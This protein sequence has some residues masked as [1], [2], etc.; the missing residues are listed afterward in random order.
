MRSLHRRSEHDGKFSAHSFQN[1]QK[2][3]WLGGVYCRYEGVLFELVRYGDTAPVR[4]C[5]HGMGRHPEEVVL[6]KILPN[7]SQ[8]ND[9]YVKSL[10]FILCLK[11]LSISIL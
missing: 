2:Y 1:G 11:S 9:G 4:I 8:V 10:L 6:S 7:R 3:K 5:Q